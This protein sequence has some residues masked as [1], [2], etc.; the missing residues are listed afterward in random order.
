M[1]ALYWTDLCHAHFLIEPKSR[2]GAP[3]LI[4]SHDRKKRMCIEEQATT[5]YHFEI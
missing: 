2:D 4:S 3:I 1:D 5:E